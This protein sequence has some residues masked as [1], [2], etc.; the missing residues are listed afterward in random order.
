VVIALLT[1]SLALAQDPPTDPVVTVNQDGV[2]EIVVYGDAMVDKARRQ[3]IY[4]LQQMGYTDVVDKG[5][6][7]RLRN[8]DVWK[9]EIHLYDDGWIRMKRQPVRLK[10]PD[11][12]RIAEEGSALSWASCLLYPPMCVRTGG[13]LLSRRKWM[14]VQGET[15]ETV[16]GDAQNLGDRVADAAVDERIN[17]LPAR[18]EALW[19]E[20]VPLE[21]GAAPMPTMEQRKAA[22]LAFWDSRTDTI[23][24]DRVRVAVEAFVRAEVQTTPWG[25]TPQ[26]VA[27][28]NATRHC[29]RALDL[30][31]PWDDV[32]AEIEP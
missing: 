4:D 26:E 13:Q 11:L 30:E 20:G 32:L 17:E 14:G 31:R 22:I 1:L 15:L 23:W 24:G 6:Y 7:V 28:F 10:S 27:A 2:S 29:E 9:G 16:Q 18:L 21:D 12:G 8:E 3:L 5:D 25:F 19:T